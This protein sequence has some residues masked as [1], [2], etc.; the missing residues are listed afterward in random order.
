MTQRITGTNSGIDVDT[1]VKESLLNEQ[2][3]IDKAYQQQMVYTYQEEQLNTVLTDGQGFYDKYLDRLSDTN[4]LSTSKYQT[5]KFTS[6]DGTTAVTAKGYA[7]AEVGNYDVSIS[8]IA[9]KA[10]TILKENS[11]QDAI[12]SGNGVLA[13]TMK[14]SEGKDVTAYVDIVFTDGEINMD[15]TALALNT[16]LKRQG[17]NVNAKYSEF[18]KGIVL[19]SGDSGEKVKFGT[20]VVENHSVSENTGTDSEKET[21]RN[22][23]SSE[24]KYHYGQNAKGTITK[25]SGNNAI[26]YQ[27]DRVNNTVLIDSV[28]FTFNSPTTGSEISGASSSEH[29]SYSNP[30]SVSEGTTVT[31]EGSNGKTTVIKKDHIVTKQSYKD[32][33]T[34]KAI[35]TK[36]DVNT[37]EYNDISSFLNGTGT[38]TFTKNGIKIS[39]SLEDGET[40]TLVSINGKTV[41]FTRVT[42]SSDGTFTKD[43]VTIKLDASKLEVNDQTVVGNLGALSKDDTNASVHTDVDG[44]ITVRKDGK[45]TIIETSADGNT[46][47]TTTRKN[48]DNGMTVKTTLVSTKSIDPSTHK[49]VTNTTINSEVVYG[50]LSDVE[51]NYYENPDLKITIDTEPTTSGADY[52]SRKTIIKNTTDSEGNPIQKITTTIGKDDGTSQTITTDKQITASATS[53]NPDPTF[54]TEETK[55]ASTAKITLTGEKD[56]STIKDTIVKF[57]EDYNTF[58]KSI[59]DKLWEKRDKDYM[60]LTD[61]Q[62]K[63]MSDSEIEAWEKKA[64]TGL[65][66]NDSDLRRIQSE[67]KSAMSTVMSGT[68]LYLESIGIERIKNNYT[69]KDGMFKVDES[70]LT[71]ALENNAG[72][73]MDLFT[74]SASGD[75]KGGVLTQLQSVFNDE[76]NSSK[77]SLSERIG[78]EGTATENDNTL[79]NYIQKQKDLITQLKKK[80]TTKE[81]ALYNKYSNLEVMLEKLNAQSNSL[82]SL[83]GY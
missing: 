9:K 18:S 28:E 51:V 65:L 24:Y 32:G 8:Q 78:L 10:S 49:T 33:I 79:G 50:S 81:T 35:T 64:K 36:A 56:V 63:E 41:D 55:G 16:E 14:N 71:E 47:T 54:G 59:N 6:S 40:K 42:A 19:E 1:V 38:G 17:I 74:R 83:I 23:F 31:L 13:V 30:D 75:D 68:G 37:T 72:E 67:M 11:F 48:Y 15:S 77:S 53:T 73:V 34:F 29:A 58:I 57:I 70:K 69:T 22:Y 62:K 5:L 4:L 39:T 20:A 45:T 44:T 80:Y 61:E 25:G 26:V 21:F 3:K 60:P 7:G 76:F 82:M 27:I 46:I 66:R 43:G 2:N 52:V 12:D